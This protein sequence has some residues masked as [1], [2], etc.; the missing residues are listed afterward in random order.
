MSGPSIDATGFHLHEFGGV[1]GLQGWLDE[2]IDQHQG[3][4]G[5]DIAIDPESVDGEWLSKE[6]QARNDAEQIALTLYNMNSPVGAVGTALSRL[7]Q[8]T[9]ITRKGAQ[10]SIAPVTLGGTPSTVVPVNSLFDDPDDPDLPPFKTV[11]AYTIGGGGTVSG[12]GVCTEAGPFNV[13]AGKLTHPLDVISGWDTVTNPSAAAPG[14]LVEP[15]PILRVRRAE[16]VAMPSQSMLDGLQSALNNLDGVDDVVVYE[17]ATGATNAKGDPAHS[18]HA[19]I[20][21]GIDADIANAIWAKASMGCTKVGAVALTVTDT[22]GNP[23]EMRWDVPVDV[24]VYI[25]VHLSRTPTSFES[26][27][28]KAALVAFG[29]TTSRIGNNVPWGD[30]FSPIN[31]LEITGGPGLPSVLSMMLGSAPSPVLQADLSVAFNARPR[32]DVARVLVVAP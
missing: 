5:D 12:Q 18:I 2:L 11:A 19:I 4:Y 10:F 22:Q 28:I 6:A 21:G 27:S 20:D 25:T 14:R 16:S 29:Q 31:D 3:I 23:Q 26:D 15:D 8:L 13:G 32:Y 24:N 17:N 9:G 7:V 30:L 1:T